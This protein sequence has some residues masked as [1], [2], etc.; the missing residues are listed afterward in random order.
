M[1]MCTCLRKMAHIAFDIAQRASMIHKS[2]TGWR[3]QRVSCCSRETQLQK[4]VESTLPKVALHRR[5]SARYTG[6]C[7][8][9]PLPKDD[10][11][12]GAAH[13]TGWRK[14]GGLNLIAGQNQLNEDSPTSG[15]CPY[16][17]S[18]SRCAAPLQLSAST[19]NFHNAVSFVV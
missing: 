13:K 9:D 18:A 6:P 3:A 4:L 5:Y 7:G 16:K 19:S 1:G 8:Q 10:F 12:C 14:I 11:C 2:S 17:H 15:P